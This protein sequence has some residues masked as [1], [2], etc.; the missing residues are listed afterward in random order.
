MVDALEWSLVECATHALY[1]CISTA[2]LPPVVMVHPHTSYSSP[3]SVLWVK[4]LSAAIFSLVP[5][6]LSTIGSPALT[7]M[8]S[9]SNLCE[10]SATWISQTH[11]CDSLGVSI[12]S[13]LCA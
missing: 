9:Y 11:R 1:S 3:K 13:H 4:D 12:T 10:G 8:P 2:C 7:G 5:R 6:C